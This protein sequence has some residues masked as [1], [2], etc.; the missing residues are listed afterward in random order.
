MFRLLL[1]KY[2][3]ENKRLYLTIIFFGLIISSSVIFRYYSWD[4]YFMYC[5]IIISSMIFA[6]KFT[7]IKTNLESFSV[8]LP[9][10]RNILVS[11][12]FIFSW[13]VFLS[14]IIFFGLNAYVSDRLY[15]DPGTDINMLINMKTLFMSV[16]FF[17]IFISLFSPAIFK[18]KIIGTIILF[19][20]SLTMVIA[21]L[22]YIFEPQTGRYSPYFSEGEFLPMLTTAIIMLISLIVSFIYSRYLYQRKEI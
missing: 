7:E 20:V 9:A 3:L 19:I 15:T 11:V 12:K 21:V 1:R 2:F 22:I 4:V 16:C 14:G 17:S 5:C 10:S 18:F 13:L 6:S 8:S